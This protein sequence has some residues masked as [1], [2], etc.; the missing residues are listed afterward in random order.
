[1]LKLLVKGKVVAVVLALVFLACAP[2]KPAPVAPPAATPVGVAPTPAAPAAAKPAEEVEWDKVVAAAKKEGKVTVYSTFATPDYQ[3]VFGGL[4]KTKYGI[5]VEWLFGI[6]AANAEKIR[7]EHETG[8]VVGDVYH[9]GAAAFVPLAKYLLPFDPPEGRKTAKDVWHITPTGYDPDKRV[10]AT[11]LALGLTP[12]VNTNLVKPQDYPKSF[13]DMLDP[14]WKG[15]MNLQDTTFAG[16]G[17]R[18]FYWLSKVYGLSFWEQMAQQN[19]IF[20]RTYSDQ[21]T[22]LVAGEDPLSMYVN[23]PYVIESAKAR[24]PV[25]PLLM[26]EGLAAPTI[27]MSLLSNSPHPNAAKVFINEALTDQGQATMPVIGY[28]PIRKGVKTEWPHP[29]IAKIMA[30]GPVTTFDLAS[31]QEHDKQIRDKVSARMLRLGEFAK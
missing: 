16:G 2:A 24:A 23:P 25:E 12:W 3:R 7:V 31:D 20:V 21:V 1:M 29:L 9:G 26:A 4:M 27:G 6:G 10:V 15:K 5:T 28:S 18:I 19:I 17:S 13:R 30:H 22:R 11:A 8:Q 14:K